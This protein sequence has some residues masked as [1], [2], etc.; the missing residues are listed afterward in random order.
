MVAYMPYKVQLH[1]IATDLPQPWVIGYRR[2]TLFVREFW[3]F[4]R[5]PGRRAAEAPAPHRPLCSRPAL[6]WPPAMAAGGA[7]RDRR[8]ER[9]SF[10]LP[11]PG[12]DPARI[13]DIYRARSPPIFDGCTSYDHLRPGVS[14]A[15]RGRR[16]AAAPGRLPHLDR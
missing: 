4:R 2:A 13:N 12:F 14:C 11:R 9:Y 6:R 1:R 10:P 15:E 7:D 5:R 16:H 8:C 3:Q